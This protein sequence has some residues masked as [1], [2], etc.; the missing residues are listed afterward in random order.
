MGLGRAAS[1]TGLEDLRAPLLGR[2]L[3]SLPPH[4]RPRPRRGF[5]EGVVAAGHRPFLSPLLPVHAPGRA[6]LH[7]ATAGRTRCACGCKKNLG[8]WT[9]CIGCGKPLPWVHHGRG[10]SSSRWSNDWRNQ[11]DRGDRGR[12]PA[13]EQDASVDVAQSDNAPNKAVAYQAVLKAIGD[14][15]PE[16]TSTVQAKMEEAKAAKL[17]AKPAPLQVR[18]MAAALARKRKQLERSKEDASKH[19]KAIEESKNL[20]ASAVADVA[21]LEV[22]VRAME[23]EVNSR[24]INC[25]LLDKVCPQIGLLPEAVRNDPIMLGIGTQVEKAIQ[26]LQEHVVKLTQQMRDSQGPE[27]GASPPVAP[28]AAHGAA[29]DAGAHDAHAGADLAAAAATPISAADADMDVDPLQDLREAL[30]KDGVDEGHAS[31]WIERAAKRSRFDPDHRDNGAA[32]AASVAQE[33]TQ[34]GG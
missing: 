29:P 9:W 31:Q 27:G 18:D 5:P 16:L 15:D 23:A 21:K 13:V 19:A 24:S 12:P 20:H 6:L 2:S 4:R 3:G 1:A 33:A 25:G 28:G 11:R 22:E 14:A 7:M 8:S 10:S 26:A 34:Q 30:R 32:P 17:A